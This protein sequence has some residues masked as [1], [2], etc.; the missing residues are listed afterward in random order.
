MDLTFTNRA[1][2][3][4]GGFAI[5]FNK[6]SF[7]VAPA[8]PIPNTPLPQNQSTEISLLLNASKLLKTTHTSL[9]Q[10]EGVIFLVYKI[11]KRYAIC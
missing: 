1:M 2:Q 3:P 7:G 6:N 10:K 8:V 11:Y 5:Q 4:M 9:L